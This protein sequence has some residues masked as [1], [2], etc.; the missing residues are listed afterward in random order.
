MFLWGGVE[1]ELNTWILKIVF[2]KMNL[3]KPCDI[4]FN[5]NSFKNHL[6]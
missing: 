2:V 6:K 3:Q 1:L 4:F 5:R